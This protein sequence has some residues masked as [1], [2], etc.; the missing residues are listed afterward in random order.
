[1]AEATVSD[2]YAQV[3]GFSV[4]ISGQAGKEVDNAWKSVSGGELII[5]L[6]ETTIG[7]DKFKTNS[8]G[9]KSVGEVTLRGDMT[10]GR[11][12]MCE[13]INKTVQSNKDWK[14]N[15]TITE[16]L[17]SDGGVK[18]GKKYNY[19]DGFPT[20]YV[21]PKMSVTNTTGNVEE[22]VRLKFVRFEM[23]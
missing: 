16:L 21:F 23:Q 15:L 3:M 7:G 4:E 9:H 5:E 2:K 22:E 17:S 6:T 1:M 10:D 14:R 19:F 13:W 11:K 12:A 8:P 20:C 18:P